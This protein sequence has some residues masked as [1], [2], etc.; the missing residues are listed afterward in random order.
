MKK[1][2]FFFIF[3][4]FNFLFLTI[5]AKAETESFDIWLKSFEKTALKN[6]ISKNKFDQAMVNVKFLPESKRSL[7]TPEIA[8]YNIFGHE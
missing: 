6:G 1:T 7:P 4:I 3:I 5:S 8:F 2:N